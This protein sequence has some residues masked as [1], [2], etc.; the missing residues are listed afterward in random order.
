[1]SKIRSHLSWQLYKLHKLLKPEEEEKFIPSE[2][3]VY[4]VSYPRSG[5]TWMRVMLAE[6]MYGESGD[7]LAD[8]GYY[9]P[10]SK[11]P[12]SIKNTIQSNFHIIKTHD[13]FMRNRLSENFRKVIYLVRDPRDVVISWHRFSSVSYYKFDLDQFIFEWVTGRIYPTSWSTHVSSW[14]GPGYEKI[15]IEMCIIK[16]ED[17]L[18][19]T[20]TNLQKVADFIDLDKSEDELRKA[21]KKGSAKQ[22]RK[23]EKN[24]FWE[25][26]IDKDKLEF[27]GDATKN[28]WKTKL[29]REQIELIEKYSEIEMKQFGYL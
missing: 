5:N 27:I 22:M 3:D 4:L 18:V 14:T 29:T 7:S 12:Q 25:K 1:M 19:D 16:Y 24:G 26:D 2:K 8:L 17:L 20:I 28:Q 23:K 15:N 11:K 10:D 21:V 9:M 13:P 6:L